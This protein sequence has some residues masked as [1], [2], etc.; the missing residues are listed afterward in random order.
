MLG[1]T[2]LPAQQA[3]PGPAAQMVVTVEPRHEGQ[4]PAVAQNDVMVYSGKEQLQV[5]DWVPATNGRAPAEV[6][7][8][9]D[10]GANTDIGTQFTALKQFFTEL[11]Q[12]TL[13][14][15]GYMR[16]G[17]VDRVQGLTSDHVLVAS[18]L[19]LPMASPG[20]DASP[21]FSL[22]DLI[23][24]WPATNTSD[25]GVRR[26]VLMITDGVDRYYGRGADNPYVDAA[27][28]EAQRHGIVVS[29]IYWSSI[30]HFGHS[31]FLINWGQ[32]YL[33]QVAQETG[34]EAYWE[35]FG[36]PVSFTPYLNDFTK[37]LSGQFLLTF[38]PNPRN[39]PGLENV[40]V[41]TELK[42]VDLVAPQAVWVQ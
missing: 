40:K 20:A 23:K 8:L 39:K 21:Y 27:F 5:L 14:G 33:A 32:N 30:G 26:E 10:E 34:G 18:K 2:G 4:T 9:I 17:T 1:V 22:G 7:V 12:G 28:A 29:S 36:N 19:R 24:H 35:G 11:P 41:K 13:V 16:N 37:R 38:R 25:T 6:F 31:H 42:D 15:L 3:S